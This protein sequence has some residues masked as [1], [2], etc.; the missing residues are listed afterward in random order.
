MLQ[1]NSETR[2]TQ[3]PRI[4]WYRSPVDRQCLKDL[5]RKSDLKGFL[6]AGGHLA[7]L[8]ATGTCAFL[9]L[10]RLAWSWVALIVF[11]H[12]TFYCCLLNGIHELVHGT[13]FKTDRLN[14]VFAGVY[15]FLLGFD[16]LFFWTSHTEH[17]KYTLH[18]PDD[19]EVMLPL[20][21]TVKKFFL[22]GFINPA[23]PVGFTHVLWRYIRVS[24]GH[25][26][27]EWEMAL[28][29][30]DDPEKRRPLI[31]WARFMLIGHGLILA[32]SIYFKLWLLPLLITFAPYYGRWLVYIL[33]YSQHGGLVDNVT[34]YRLCCR[35]IRLNPFIQFLYWHMNF[36]TEH[37][38]YAS[39]PC[40]N[41]G[42]L[43]EHIKHDLPYCPKGL[44]ATWMQMLAIQ[45]K[46]KA[47]SDYQYVAPLPEPATH[48]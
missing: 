41:L 1:T 28:F 23:G 12:G 47:D 33:T 43:H 8:A 38:M 26:T 20:P 18:P 5:G 37:H 15:S 22:H 39:I 9:A 36:H 19:L 30:P 46:Q 25:F 16:H 21:L 2:R 10:G 42:K 14:R 32:I 31:R 35:T 7:L 6:Q 45:K 3:K 48:T 17:H 27:G 44:W 34:D 13:V 4:Q 40:Y 29:P 11:C 24:C